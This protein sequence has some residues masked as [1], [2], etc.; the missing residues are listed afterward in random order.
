MKKN[1]LFANIRKIAIAFL[2]L[3][4]FSN[5][6]STK[7]VKFGEQENE[8]YPSANLK[9]FLKENKS[10]KV[11]LRVHPTNTD[12]A[13]SERNNY[14]YDAIE[15][16]LLMQGFTVRDRQLFN[17]VFSTSDSN[18]DYTRLKSRTDTDLII[19]L[20]KLDSKEVYQTNKYITDKGKDGLL[21]YNYKRYG[22][23][24]EFKIV[25]ISN[26][27]FAGTY[28][29]NYA[30]CNEKYPCQINDSFNKRWKAVEKGKKGYEEVDKN[31]MEEFIR[32]ATKQ[33]VAS[34]RQ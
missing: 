1:N 9:I 25:M 32:E 13:E 27:E 17:Q 34:M 18:T 14:L 3:A 7:F 33:L 4:S 31:V 8:I 21:D 29:F 22:A 23:K 11:V 24:V 2:I 10:P 20:S 30:P 5:C 19:E 12:L 15:K 16:E 28:T 26:N 6:S